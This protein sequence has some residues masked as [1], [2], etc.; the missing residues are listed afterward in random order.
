MCYVTQKRSDQSCANVTQ[1]KSEGG[2]SREREREKSKEESVVS[3][4]REMYVG[5]A[6]LAL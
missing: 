4:V 6:F 1:K 2:L 5:H 3:E